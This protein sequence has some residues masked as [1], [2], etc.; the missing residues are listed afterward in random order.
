MFSFIKITTVSMSD[1]I[2]LTDIL[3]A[4]VHNY[5]YTHI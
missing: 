1:A 5:Q 4:C 2:L 3:Y